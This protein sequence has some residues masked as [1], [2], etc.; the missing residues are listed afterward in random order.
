MGKGIIALV[1]PNEINCERLSDKRL[2]ENPIIL[3][4]ISCYGVVVTLS[5]CSRRVIAG[6]TIPCGS[7]WTNGSI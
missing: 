2:I 5:W 6:G 1:Q 3:R 4:S 7:F